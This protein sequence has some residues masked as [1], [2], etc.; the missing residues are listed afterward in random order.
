M[1]TLRR[2]F[3]SQKSSYV[4]VSDFRADRLKN[5]KAKVDAK[6]GNSDCV[7]LP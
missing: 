6:Y 4:A 3:H 1:D 5:A 2:S 7:S